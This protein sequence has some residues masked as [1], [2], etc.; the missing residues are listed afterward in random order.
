MLG[1][2]SGC[3]P[4]CIVVSGLLEEDLFLFKS[5]PVSL[6]LSKVDFSSPPP[7]CFKYISKGLSIRLFIILILNNDKLFH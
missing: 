7:C 6:I 2:Q 3:T 5:K 4:G 1:N